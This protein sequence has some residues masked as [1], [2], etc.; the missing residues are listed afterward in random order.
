MSPDNTPIGART[1]PATSPA[2]LLMLLADPGGRAA[3]G[4]DSSRVFMLLDAA[5]DPVIHARLTALGK[6]VQARSMYQGD[7]G[8]HLA[9]VSPYLLAIAGED[10]PALWFATA[11][12]GKSWG[13]FVTA[14]QSFG[15]LRRH[16]RKFNLVRDEAGT[17]LVFRYYDPRVLRIFLPTCTSEELR[18][19]FGP[20]ESFAAETADGQ[21]LARFT[22]AGGRL[23]TSLTPFAPRS[24]AIGMPS[25]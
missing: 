3:E 12:L 4:P 11:G 1:T 9:H 13:V 21:G 18:R 20:V 6:D 2:A 5:R 23:Q 8:E 15:D 16:L 22:L 7:L 25:R 19:F 24:A 14:R 17:P 10:D